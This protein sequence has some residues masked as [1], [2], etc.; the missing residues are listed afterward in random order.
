MSLLN[1]V[2]KKMYQDKITPPSGIGRRFKDR[3]RIIVK[4]IKDYLEEHQFMAGLCK[5]ATVVSVALTLGSLLYLYNLFSK[6]H[7]SVLVSYAQIGVEVRRR[8]NLIPNLIAAT[9]K[10]A[11]HEEEA[12]KYVSDARDMLMHA[13]NAKEN[14][15]MS[16]QLDGALSKLL[17]IAEQYP[18]LKATQSMQDLIKELANTENRIAEKKVEYNKATYHYNALLTEFPSNVLGKLYGFWPPFE[19]YSTQEDK[20]ENPELLSEWNR[21][22]RELAEGINNKETVGVTAGSVPEK[23]SAIP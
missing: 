11:V 3:C 7:T 2:V 14:A 5:V 13:K 23:Q 1:T 22:V 4:D 9:K 21:E 15:K 17:A 20:I 6:L 18:D 19:Y 16:S 12:F 10:Y 8:N